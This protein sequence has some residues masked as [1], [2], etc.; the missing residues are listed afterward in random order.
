MSCWRERTALR[1]LLYFDLIHYRPKRFH[2]TVMVDHIHTQFN[3]NHLINTNS[4][5]NSR[6]C[7]RSPI[8]STRSHTKRCDV[9]D[10]RKSTELAAG[11]AVSAAA[12]TRRPTPSLR[13][14]PPLLRPEPSVNFVAAGGANSAA[15]EVFSVCVFL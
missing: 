2:P 4:T 14:E 8:P 3:L 15:G 12:G 5:I 6:D 1:I 13:A 11:A 10:E 9:R 7:G